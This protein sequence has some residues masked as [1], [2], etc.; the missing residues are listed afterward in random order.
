MRFNAEEGLFDLSLPNAAV[1]AGNWD[2]VEEGMVVQAVITG[3]NK[4]GLD[5][6]VG[7]LRGLCLSVRLPSFAWKS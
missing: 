5:C 6:T 4:G 1:D 7:S 2:E 3:H